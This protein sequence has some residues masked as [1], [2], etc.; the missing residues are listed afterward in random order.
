MR[1]EQIEECIMRWENVAVLTFT[2][3][4]Q[5][6]IFLVELLGMGLFQKETNMIRNFITA[7]P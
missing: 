5:S 4:K 1:V 2:N 7:I 6:K 3:D